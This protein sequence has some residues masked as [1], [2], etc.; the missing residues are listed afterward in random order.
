MAR[1]NPDN[2]EL[3]K[4]LIGHYPRPKSALIPLLHLAQEQDG[5][6]SDEAMIHIA[7]LVGVTPAEV[8][9]TCSFYEMFKREPVGKYLVNICHGIAC[10][11]M[12]AEDL[13]SHAEDTLGVKAGSTTA[14]GAITIERAECQA[15]C[16]EAPCLQVNYRYR[17]R[18]T[19]EDFDRLVAQLRAGSLDD[20]IPPHGT[21]SR[22]AFRQHIPDERRNGPA[23]VEGGGEPVWIKRHREMG[24]REA[25]EAQETAS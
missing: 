10:A 13:I 21:L 2:T 23:L 9:G 17:Y 20:E 3:A 7:E 8:L 25:A 5:Y 12:G 11:L 24:Q 6:V 18:V 22:P 16:T 15:A 19:D 14:D 1:L 4:E